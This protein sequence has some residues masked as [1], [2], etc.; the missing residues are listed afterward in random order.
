MFQRNTVATTAWL[1]NYWKHQAK[2]KAQWPTMCITPGDREKD[3]F[4]DDYM[5]WFITDEVKQEAEA[6]LDRRMW[7]A[8]ATRT[9]FFRQCVSTAVKNHGVEQ[10]ILLGSGF[11]TLAVRKAKYG[12]QYVEVD[13]KAVLDC[14]AAVYAEHQQS[15]NATYLPLDY[16]NDDLIQALTS[17]GVDFK[18]PTLILWEGNVFYLE[19]HQVFTILD[20]LSK[21]FSE[22]TL[23]FDFMHAEM[24]AKTA[25]LDDAGGEQSLQKTLTTFAKQKSPFKSYFTPEEIK[26]ACAARGLTLLACKTTATLAETYDVDKTPYY[27]AK[28]YSVASFRKGGVAFS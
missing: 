3:L 20:T 8:T 6:R 26:E 27:T 5:A 23:A 18:K 1:V 25:S 13:A 4:K 15:T 12:V 7:V 17:H 10:V 22:F 2:Q 14:K 11:D 9:K 28:P 16:V 19:R 24:Q 21:N